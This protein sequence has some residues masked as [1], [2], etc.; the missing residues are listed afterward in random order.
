M[1]ND[2]NNLLTL[3]PIHHYRLGPTTKRGEILHIMRSFHTR[4]HN[5]I[6][7]TNQYTYSIV[8]R[9]N[10]Y[11]GNPLTTKCVLL[12]DIVGYL[13]CRSC[14]RKRPRK[15][16]DDNILIFEVVTNLNPLGWEI[17]CKEIYRIRSVRWKHQYDVEAFKKS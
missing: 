7:N 17:F 15:S 8:H 3:C 14:R 13:L 6:S 9:Q 16:N 2:Q 10:N 1:Q 12:R 5:E 4:K 11:L